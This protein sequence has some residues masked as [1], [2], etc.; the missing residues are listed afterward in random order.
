MAEAEMRRGD[1]P[2]AIKGYEDAIRMAQEIRTQ[3]S[4]A[5]YV[6]AIWGLS[7]AL[8][9]Y[10][11]E[12]GAL[13]EAKRA[14]SHDGKLAII[15]DEENVFFVPEYERDYYKGLGEIAIATD[16]TT[17]RERVQHLERAERRFSAYVRGA[18]DTW[19]PPIGQTDL[20]EDRWLGRA[21]KHVLL[22]RAEL[23]R[24]RG[25]RGARGAAEDEEIEI[26]PHH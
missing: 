8:D 10:G 5:S 7:V 26:G 2:A 25:A 18:L 21:K 11:D 14:V 16:A 9:R 24:A 6:L 17:A 12:S 19:T 22:I 23:V 4:V 20:K 13:R 1:L 15:S 3:S